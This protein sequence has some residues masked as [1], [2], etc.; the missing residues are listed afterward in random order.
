MIYQES[1]VTSSNELRELSLFVEWI[2]IFICFELGLMLLLK[3]KDVR[4]ESNY[5]QELGYSILIFSYGG[6]WIC[7]LIADFYVPLSNRHEILNI[8]YF[9]LVLG[10]FI[11]IIFALADIVKTSA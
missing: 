11:F 1:F 10:A 4:K 3:F 5:V 2:F 9:I 6:Q 8:G 7:F